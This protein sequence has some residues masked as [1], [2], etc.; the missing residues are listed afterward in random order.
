[1]WQPV[2]ADTSNKT[3]VTAQVHC[4]LC[5]CVH[6]MPSTASLMSATLPVSSTFLWCAY[7]STM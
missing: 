5:G 2:I 1:M 6:H 3:I 4:S 7:R